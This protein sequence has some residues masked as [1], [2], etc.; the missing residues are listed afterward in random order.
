MA[1]KKRIIEELDEWGNPIQP[2][3]AAPSNKVSSAERF[4]HQSGMDEWGMEELS[5]TGKQSPSPASR[6]FKSGKKGIA[7]LAVCMLGVVILLGGVLLAGRIFPGGSPVGPTV[8]HST[9]TNTKG[10]GSVTPTP[11]PA[12]P[13]PKSATPTPKPSTPTPKPATPTPQPATPTPK[14]ATPTPKPATPTPK[15]VT[16]TPTAN[17]MAA[18]DSWYD[19]SQR[20]FYQQ[21]TDKEKRL[22][23]LLYDC[24][25]RF[26]SSVDIQ[27]QGYTER[28]VERVSAVLFH[29]TPELFQFTGSITRWTM[30]SQLTQL[31]PVYRMDAATYRTRTARIQGIVSSIRTSVASTRDE[32]WIEYAAY[33]YLIEHCDYNQKEGKTATADSALCDGEAQCAGYARSLSLLCRML[34][35]H[36]TNATSQSLDHEWNNIR[37]NGRWYICDVTWDDGRADEYQRT[38]EPGQNSFL[39]YMNLPERLAEKHRPEQEM[40]GLGFT[41]PIITSE[42]AD[43]YVY[44][45]GVYLSGSAANSADTVTNQLRA[46]YN[47]GKRKIML[48]LDDAA[49]FRNAE[50][51]TLKFAQ[52]H[53]AV[54]WLEDKDETEHR[55]VFIEAN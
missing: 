46:A 11:K 12:T 6:Q 4:E 50:P 26:D 15:P 44:R 3:E 21:L 29:D 51:L 45:E 22:F 9:T 37:I 54:R 35:L 19:A 53:G 31:D 40:T 42:V 25:M 16:P 34:G 8:T 30:G 24:I 48:M 41:F 28:E 32:F 10:S 27:G 20:Y 2:Y 5:H 1:G 14:P 17:L 13:T 39:R 38:F 7:A 23:A 47:S 55:T 18:A 49:A 33:R 52:E 36:C 43:N